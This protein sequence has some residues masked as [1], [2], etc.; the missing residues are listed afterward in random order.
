MAEGA[1][2]EL[3]SSHFLSCFQDFRGLI[4]HLIHARILVSFAITFGSGLRGSDGGWMS[5]FA[6]SRGCF[7]AHRKTSLGFLSC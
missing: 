5:T 4:Y 7:L 2:V 1:T 6:S 3:N